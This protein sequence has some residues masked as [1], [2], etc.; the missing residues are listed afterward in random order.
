[1]IDYIKDDEF[2]GFSDIIIRV[3]ENSKK[4][5]AF[6]VSENDWILNNCRN[7]RRCV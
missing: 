7:S 1:M 5:V 3:M 6:S 2:I 4:V